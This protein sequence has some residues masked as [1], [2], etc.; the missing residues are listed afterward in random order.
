MENYNY[1]VTD[2]TVTYYGESGYQI[3]APAVYEPKPINPDASPEKLRYIIAIHQKGQTD[4]ST[5]CEQAAKH[6]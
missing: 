3:A 4:F 1:S 5:F 2:G 6:V